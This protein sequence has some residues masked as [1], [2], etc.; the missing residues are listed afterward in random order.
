MSN[1]DGNDADICVQ[2]ECATLCFRT[3]LSNFDKGADVI[4]R[5]ST[6]SAN[7]GQL[8]TCRPENHV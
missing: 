6:I 3:L 5:L 2:V 7:E 1:D 4:S 8:L